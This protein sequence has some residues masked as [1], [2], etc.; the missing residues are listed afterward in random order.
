MPDAICSVDGCQSIVKCKALCSMHY[1][2]MRHTGSTER[3]FRTRTLYERFVEK[4]EKT[5]TCWNWTGSTDR[6]YGKIGLRR[7]V[8]PLY[9]HR[10]SYEFHVGPIP[11]GLQLDH[12]CRN[13]SC[14]NPAHL[15]PVTQ[16]ENL[17][18]GRQAKY[19][20]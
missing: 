6:G 18:R 2:R 11:A 20:A 7:G 16:R 9:A 5:D 19:E 10:V 13:R 4:V 1:Q 14:V 8:A 3:R 17:A 15:E 12:L